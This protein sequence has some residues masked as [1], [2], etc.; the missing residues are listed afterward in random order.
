MHMATFSLEKTL[1]PTPTTLDS[2]FVE[3]VNL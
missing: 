2:A 3:G 1:K